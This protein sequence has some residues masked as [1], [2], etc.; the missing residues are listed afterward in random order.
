MYTHTYTHTFIHTRMY[1]Y[2]YVY[3]TISIFVRCILS[4]VLHWY[5]CMYARMCFC[6][7]ALY[8]WMYVCIFCT[9][10]WTHLHVSIRTVLIMSLQAVRVLIACTLSKYTCIH[11]NIHI[12]IWTYTS[13]LLRID[14]QKAMH[15]HV[16]VKFAMH[17]DMS[18]LDPMCMCAYLMYNIQNCESVECWFIWLVRQETCCV[19]GLHMIVCGV[20]HVIV[21]VCD[22]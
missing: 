21:C 14:T 19:Y 22:T 1:I 9:H 13:V 12:H 8:E 11:T 16:H 6:M 4:N 7:Q 5:V 3:V 18:C 15:I 17:H 20:E 2:V 10:T